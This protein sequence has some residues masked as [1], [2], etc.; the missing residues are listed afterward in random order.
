[1]TEPEDDD[2]PENAPEVPSDVPEGAAVFPQ[3]PPDLGVNPLLLAVLHAYVFLDGSDAAVVHPA[4]A[5]EAL[6]YIVAYLQQLESRDLARF[7]EDIDTLVGYARE[8]KWPKAFVR[9]LKD[10]AADNGIGTESPS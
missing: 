8:Q 5:N 1:M 10:F 3:I 7:G 6:E 2:T 4:A 9:F